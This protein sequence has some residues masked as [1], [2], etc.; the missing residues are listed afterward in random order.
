MKA[1]DILLLALIFFYSAYVV[2]R[3]VKRRNDDCTHVCTTCASS[4][5]HL[6]EYTEELRKIKEKNH[7]TD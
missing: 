4:S 3:M 6:S 5:C 7:E 1:I 2:Y